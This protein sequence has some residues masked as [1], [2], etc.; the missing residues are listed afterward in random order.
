MLFRKRRRWF[1]SKEEEDRLKELFNQ[2]YT[3]KQI[4]KS[5]GRTW[6]AV[7]Q[8]AQK[9]GFR[10]KRREVVSPEEFKRFEQ[11]IELT[12]RIDSK[13][14]VLTSGKPE[15]IIIQRVDCVVYDPY[16]GG[17]ILVKSFR[18]NE[19]GDFEIRFKEPVT[20]DYVPG[21]SPCLWIRGK[22]PGEGGL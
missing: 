11:I 4:A 15:E 1:W 20:V 10:R 18:I 17:E 7:A 8:H 12:Y 9:M 6:T 19:M 3:Y 22:K 21:R 16:D 2:G 13:R 14:T 5:L